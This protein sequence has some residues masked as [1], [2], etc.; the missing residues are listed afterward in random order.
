MTTETPLGPTPSQTIGPFFRFGLDWFEPTELVVA[1]TPGART[2]GG[3]V[4][5]GAGDPVPDACVEIWQAGPDGRFDGQPVEGQATWHGWGRC[6]TDAEGRW[7]FTTQKPGRVDDEQAPHVDVTL[8]ARGLLQRLVSRIYFPDEAVANAT[9]PV[10]VAAGD[11]ASTLVA[12][13][14]PDGHLHH[15]LVLQGE[16]E[17]VFFVW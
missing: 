8:F 14:Q 7:G 4:L 1:G 11:R 13:A 2:I 16:R 12:T 5:D 17:T 15:D 6:L 9:D 3:R 10:L